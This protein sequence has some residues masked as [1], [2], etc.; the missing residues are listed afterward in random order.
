MTF[1]TLFHMFSAYQPPRVV[2]FKTQDNDPVIS[3]H[4][5]ARFLFLGDVNGEIHII[6]IQGIEFTEQEFFVDFKL[7]MVDEGDKEER[8][9]SQQGCRLVT[10]LRSHAYS[11]FIWSIQSDGFRQERE[12]LCCCIGFRLGM[13]RIS[14]F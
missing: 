14:G 2:Y 7:P 11:A 4:F 13:H 12:R 8:V 10:T 1:F 9:V 3:L 6:D 5:S